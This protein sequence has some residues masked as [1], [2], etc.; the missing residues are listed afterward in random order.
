MPR[1]ACCLQL[2]NVLLLISASSSFLFLFLSLY[3]F[4]P[5]VSPRR[6]RFEVAFFGLYFLKGLCCVYCLGF[7]GLKPNLTLRSPHRKRWF[8]DS[9]SG[10][11]LL[12]SGLCW[13]PAEGGG[14]TLW[15]KSVRPSR[16]LLSMRFLRNTMKEFFY[17]FAT[18]NFRIW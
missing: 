8:W 3:C 7:G 9:L 6:E 4:S 1:S 13:L 2:V 14:F 16:L 18:N 5:W 17:K 11:W 10:C 12:P 15:G